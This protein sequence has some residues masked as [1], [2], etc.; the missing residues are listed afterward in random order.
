VELS[1]MGHNIVERGSIGA[2]DAI[3][4]KPNG[5]LESGA[6]PRGDDFATGY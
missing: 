2:V 1:E 3:L 6:D 5:K 4:V